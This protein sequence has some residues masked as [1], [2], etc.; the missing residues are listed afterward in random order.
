MDDLQNLSLSELKDYRE[1]LEIRIDELRRHQV[2]DDYFPPYT[3]KE[4]GE[5]KQHENK[6]NAALKAINAQI[7][8]KLDVIISNFEAS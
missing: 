7:R 1:L 3:D 4:I 5:L 2:D 8:K 6:A